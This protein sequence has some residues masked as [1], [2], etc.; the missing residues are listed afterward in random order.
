MRILL[1]SLIVLF[2]T[3]SLGIQTNVNAGELYGTSQTFSESSDPEDRQSFLNK[4]DPETAVPTRMGGIGFQNCFGLDFEPGTDRLFGVCDRLKELDEG[5]AVVML[6]E[7]RVEEEDPGQ[8]LVLIDKETGE[9]TEI[10][11]LGLENQTDSGITDISFS[12]DGT[13]FGILAAFPELPGGGGEGM[14]ARQLPEFME[15]TLLTI[16]TDTGQAAEVGPTGT[17]PSFDAIGFAPNG[18]LYHATDNFLDPATFNMLDDITGNGDNI[19]NITHPP[20]FEELLSVL[21]MDHS[22]SRNQLFALFFEF[23][24]FAMGRASTRETGPGIYL[25]TID[26]DTGVMSMIAPIVQF[27][28][29]DESAEQF[30]AIAF[31]QKE[32][33]EVPTLSEYGLIATAIILM[34]SAVVFLRRRQVASG[35]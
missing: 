12:P 33:R 4:I 10:G 3:V 13:L 7:T 24:Q 21:S 32:L 6:G 34:L 26:P 30:A 15:V 5:D 22:Q 2:V 23:P 8:V 35:S 20:G 29:D 1:S 31:L 19:A 27:S 9:G 14:A 25:T 28:E 17:G 18:N 11:A 16:D